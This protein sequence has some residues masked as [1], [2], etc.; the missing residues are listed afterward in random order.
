METSS[1]IVTAWSSDGTDMIQYISVAAGA[2][3]MALI[4]TGKSNVLV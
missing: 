4:L 1:T 2:A 3:A